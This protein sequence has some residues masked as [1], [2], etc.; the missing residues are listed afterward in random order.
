MRSSCTVLYDGQCE[1]CLA[2][3]SWLRSL[4]PRGL[5]DCIPIEPRLLPSLHP[6]LRFEDCMRELHVLT[7]DGRIYVGW[8]ALA[9]LARLFPFTW[10]LG[11]LGTVPLFRWL[12][13][14]LYRLVAANRYQVE[15]VSRG[16][17][18][19][20]PPSASTFARSGS[21]ALDRCCLQAASS[22]EPMGVI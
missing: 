8:D 22:F 2:G 15:Q 11:A 14:R 4:D 5:V 18:P 12:G 10:F 17:L 13:R 3:V 9:A 7:S 16:K 21:A 1:I 20:G 19:S 6:S